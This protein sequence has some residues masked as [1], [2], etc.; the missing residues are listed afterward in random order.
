MFDCLYFTFSSSFFPPFMC[1]WWGG[2]TVEH[3]AIAISGKI[4]I[5]FQGSFSFHL[6]CELRFKSEINFRSRRHV[7]S[8]VDA[9]SSFYCRRNNL[10]ST[11][12]DVPIPPTRKTIFTVYTRGYVE[13]IP[14]WIIEKLFEYESQ[15]VESLTSIISV[16]LKRVFSFLVRS[17]RW[18]LVILASEF[19]L[20]F[21]ACP[22]RKLYTYYFN[23]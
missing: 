19:S 12:M 17:P 1:G 18:S 23:N 5:F 14:L 16:F 21:L 22:L 15:Q 4:T 6:F 20:C 8:I 2:D 9:F 10:K 11:Y 13:Q 7:P 3:L